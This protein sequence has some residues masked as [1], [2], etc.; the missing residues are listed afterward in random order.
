MYIEDSS[1]PF[2]VLENQAL[3]EEEYL[4]AQK[5]AYRYLLSG[6]KKKNGGICLAVLAGIL[7]LQIVWSLLARQVTVFPVFSMLMV[8]LLILFSFLF[9]ILLPEN[10]MERMKKVYD[11]AFYIGEEKSWAFYKEYFELKSEHEYMKIYRTDVT[12]CLE[13]NG[14]FV[15]KR[16]DGRFT[17][18]NKKRCTQ[19]QAAM[20][21]DYLKEIYVE[22]FITAA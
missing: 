17:I 13:D 14:F 10:Y 20:L 3:S 7:F 5:T 19:E 8:V 21:R 2:L 12:E 1:K 15:F 4:S 22:K 16:K 18:I 11:T 6:K 9:L